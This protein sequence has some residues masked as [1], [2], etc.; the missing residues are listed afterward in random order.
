[1]AAP[2]RRFLIAVLAALVLPAAALA[3]DPYQPAKRH[4]PADTAVAT[5]IGLVRSDF[6][7]GW[8]QVK[9]DSSDKD[10][11]K[12]EPDES[13]L[14]ETADVDPTFESS[15]GSVD[16]DSEVQIFKTAAMSRTDWSY[17]T[18]ARL[19]TCAKDEFVR[20]LGPKTTFTL[21]AVQAPVFKGLETNAFHL[22]VHATVKGQKVVVV[23]DL[24]SLHKGRISVMLSAIG[25][26]GSYQAAAL[27][28]LARVL[29]ARLTATS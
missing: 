1:M 3:A 28:P 12:G 13:K 5:R 6:V 7:A 4:T 24:I 27:Q 9:S 19:R 2:E 16:V 20:Q 21:D 17:A 25:P 14:V 8:K 18:V 23:S 29:A 11:C 22:V 10:V 26:Q 15:D